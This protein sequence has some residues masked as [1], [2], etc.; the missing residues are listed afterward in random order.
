MRAA[1]V[2]AVVARGG[3]FFVFDQLTVELIDQLVDSGI[4]VAGIGIGK[5]FCAA[6]V[7]SGLSQVMEL[8][9]VQDHVNLGD[10]V[11]MAVQLFEFLGTD[12]DIGPMSGH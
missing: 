6:N 12:C 3:F 9:Y 2:A 11:T 10:L 7:G 1:L 5:Q 8:F 4:H